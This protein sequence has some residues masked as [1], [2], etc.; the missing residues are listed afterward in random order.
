MMS[1]PENAVKRGT[2]H[3]FIFAITNEWGMI[4]VFEHRNRLEAFETFQKIQ[5][6][7]ENSMP[8]IFRLISVKPQTFYFA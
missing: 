7:F 1:D 4:G 2:K 5:F 6:Q 3:F 8:A